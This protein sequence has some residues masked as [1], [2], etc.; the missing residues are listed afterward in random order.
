[1]TEPKIDEDVRIAEEAKLADKAKTEAVAKA[2]EKAALEAAVAKDE[3]SREISAL[4]TDLESWKA[5]LETGLMA[6]MKSLDN[7]RLDVNNL[8]ASLKSETNNNL[9][10]A[11]ER[12]AKKTPIRATN[13]DIT[14][15]LNFFGPDVVNIWDKI[16]NLMKK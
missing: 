5:R 14:M 15:Y 3:A 7:Y 11:L 4:K 2:K 9:E 8:L 1:M 16:R 13:K 6:G 10:A 12:F